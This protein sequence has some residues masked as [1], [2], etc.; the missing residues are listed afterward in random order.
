MTKKL[1]SFALILCMALSLAGLATAEAPTTF[2]IFAGVSPMSPDNKDKPLVKQMNEAMNV[3][4][5][6]ECVTSDMLTERKNLLFATQDL[7]DAFMGAE[8]KDFEILTYGMDGML[9]PLNDLI[10]EENTPNLMKV[11]EKRPEALATVTMPDGNIYTLP[12]FGEMGFTYTDGNGYQ[13]GSIPQFTVINTEW[14]DA[15]GLEMPA[16]LDE[17]HDV[18]VAFRD[19]DPNGNGKQDEIPM[20]FIMKD[21]HWCANLTTLFSGFGFTDYNEFHRGLVDDTVVYNPAR[22]EFRDAIAYFHEWYA[23]GLFDMEALTQDASQYIAKGKNEDMILGSYVWWE[24]PEVVGYDRADSYAYL[25]PLAGPDGTLNLR[26]SETGTVGRDTF[27]ITSAC[28]NP[29]MLLKWVDQ[30]YDPLMSMQAIY[31]PI[32]DFF[33]AEPDANGVYVNKTPAEGTTEGE[34]KE[35]MQLRGPVAQLNEDYGTI[36]YMEDRAQERLNDLENFW[37]PYVTDF[38]S[39]PKVVFTMEEAEDINDV[40][41]DLRSYSREMIATWLMNGGVEEQWDSYLAQLENIGL[42][43]VLDAWQAAYDRFQEAL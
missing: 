18:L 7:P 9:L 30:M 6:W 15:L 27:A 36:Y 21:W 25:P 37:F 41:S 33:E 22:D 26:L 19:Q 12:S 20:S 24:I 5:E 4:V 34:M 35:I 8:L 32:G 40:V 10:N 31:G 1:I 43:Q 42:Q 13:I 29:E 39:Y 14:L 16:T 3:D 2:R 28:E 11:L 23:E 38:T 17:L